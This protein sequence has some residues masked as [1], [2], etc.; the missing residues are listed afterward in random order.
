MVEQWVSWKG[1]DTINVS[2]V[3]NTDHSYILIQ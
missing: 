2:S 3:G 1:T